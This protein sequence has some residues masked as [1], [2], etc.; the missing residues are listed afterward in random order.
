MF[1]T[2]A[3]WTLTVIITLASVVYQR[4][5]GPTHPMRSSVEVDG[6]EISYRLLRSHETTGD[7]VIR[8]SV[9][10]TAVFAEMT[11]KRFK[12][13]DSLQTRALTRETDDLVARIPKQPSA[14]KVMYRIALIDG[15]GRR[16]DLTDDWVIIRFTG[17]VPRPVLYMHVLAMFVGMALS[18]RTGLEAISG[19]RR[20]YGY[21]L[22]TTGLI[23]LGGLILGPV[24]QK[25]AFGAFWT[26]WPIGHD[27]TDNKTAIAV[28]FWLIALWRLRK[29]ATSKTWVIVAAIVTLAVYLVPHS[30]L[31]SELDYTKMEATGLDQP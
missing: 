12:S 11:Y 9:P 14:G 4:L 6:A 7:A 16:Y 25:Y 29:R 15:N 30:V 28:I 8:I 18:T 3:L 22:L 10:D 27:L 26:G 24:V 17:P 2:I 19:G 21:A 20:T 31:G 23:V 1:R 5:T 13:H